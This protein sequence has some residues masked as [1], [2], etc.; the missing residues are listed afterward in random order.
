MGIE[1]IHRVIKTSLVLAVL[2]LLFVTVYYDFKFAA[3]ILAGCVWGC[4]NLYFMTQLITEIFAPG[5]EVKKR[6]VVLISVVKF[7]L[8]YAA[9]YLL[10]K[11][12]YFPPLSLICGF[13]LIFLVIFLKAL[14][15]WILSMNK[16]KDER[17]VS[18]KK[19]KGMTNS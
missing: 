13:T 14:G 4:L 2:I 19:I 9:G 8:L 11:T 1:F 10:L 15:R 18:G 5:K 3:G 7:P 17:S 16:E 12:S 6:K